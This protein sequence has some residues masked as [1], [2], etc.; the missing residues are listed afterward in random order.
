MTREETIKLLSILKAAYPNS[1]KGM[2]KEEASGTIAVWSMQ[3]ADIPANVMLI[4]VNKL[5]STSPFP[6]SISEVRSKLRDLY[7]EATNMLREHEYATEGFK[8][9]DD[10]NEEPAFFG[11]PLDDRTLAVVKNIIRVTSTLRNNNK[12]ETSLSDMLT[13]GS[14]R[15]Y[16]ETSGGE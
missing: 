11:N 10:P 7:Y 9:T 5:I 6:P 2:T 3:F 4:A 13:Q 14:G 15:Y 12:N 16:L 8:I 1:Y